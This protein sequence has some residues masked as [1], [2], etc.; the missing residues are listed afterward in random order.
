M[1]AHSIFF[2]SEGLRI[3]NH[4]TS[5]IPFLIQYFPLL[6]SKKSCIPET[7][8]LNG[9]KRLKTVRMAEKRLKQSKIVTRKKS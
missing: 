4:F 8:N 6:F 9:A 3:R 1:G 7:L 2:L 5:L